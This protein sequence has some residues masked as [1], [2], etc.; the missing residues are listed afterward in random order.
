MESCVAHAVQR[1]TRYVLGY[2][3]ISGPRRTLRLKRCY[4]TT[5]TE[6]QIELSEETE[7]AQSEVTGVFAELEVTNYGALAEDLTVRV[8]ALWFITTYPQR[9]VKVW[10]DPETAKEYTNTELFKMAGDRID[11]LR[12][13]ELVRYH[14]DDYVPD[15]PNKVYGGYQDRNAVLRREDI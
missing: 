6:K 3:Y 2:Y 4:A 10:F 14:K 15:Y 13:E 9:K 12:A 5:H 1:A 8:P 11:V 7:L